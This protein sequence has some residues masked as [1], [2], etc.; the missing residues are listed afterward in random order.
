[1]VELPID[2]DFTPN[3]SFSVK[4]SLLACVEPDDYVLT[5]HG[6]IS[7]DDD[8]EIG[9]LLGY[10]IQV[11]RAI[12]EEQDLFEACDAPSIVRLVQQRRLD[13]ATYQPIVYPSG[14]PVDVWGGD[15]QSTEFELG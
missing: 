7:S 5:V 2:E 6:S 9:R 1:M 12:N 13:D 14:T 10:I 15:I 8:R 11:N 3:I 4:R